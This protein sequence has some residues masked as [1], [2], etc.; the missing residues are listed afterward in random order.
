MTKDFRNLGEALLSPTRTFAPVV[1]KILEENDPKSISGLIHSTGG[2]HSK[3]K[4]FIEQVT[5]NKKINWE[6]PEVFRL[7]QREAGID[8]P[9][10]F[11]T[12]NCGVR[13]EV[14]CKPSAVDNIEE[15]CREFNLPVFKIGT[16]TKSNEAMVRIQS[17]DQKWSY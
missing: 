14:Y 11:R 1:K 16:V 6:V 13:M 17:A 9:E 3:V 12:F 15:I 5:V 2:S 7:I 4:N 8:D 10:L